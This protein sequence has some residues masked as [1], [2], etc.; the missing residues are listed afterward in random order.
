MPISQPCE[1][2]AAVEKAYGEIMRL[3]K[4]KYRIQNYP[5]EKGIGNI[6]YQEER[7]D[8]NAAFKEALR[9]LFQLQSWEDF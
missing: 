2:T 1:D 9:L 8:K 6:D 4:T 3:L 7:D 5:A